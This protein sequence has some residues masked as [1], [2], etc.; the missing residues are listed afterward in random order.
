MIQ[1]VTENAI[2]YALGIAT[3]VVLG[4]CAKLMKTACGCC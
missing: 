3:V 1:I 2:A 4:C